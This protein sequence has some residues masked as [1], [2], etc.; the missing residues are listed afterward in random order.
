MQSARK[1]ASISRAEKN[2]CV[3]TTT[4]GTEY[5]VRTTSMR[6]RA[7]WSKLVVG[8]AIDFSIRFAAGRGIISDV[9]V[10]RGSG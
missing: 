5:F 4:D 2:Y 3:G 9:V 7:E 1:Q 8:D 10:V 6:V